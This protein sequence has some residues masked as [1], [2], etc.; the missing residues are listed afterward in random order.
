MSEKE[1]LN[2]QVEEICLSFKGLG[3]LIDYVSLDLRKDFKAIQLLCMKDG[4]GEQ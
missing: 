2:K 1:E 4:K 3:P